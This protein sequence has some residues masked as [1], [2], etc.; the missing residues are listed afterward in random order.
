MLNLYRILRWM[1]VADKRLTEGCGDAPIPI[2][3]LYRRRSR[4]GFGLGA[5]RTADWS[6][7][8]SRLL[9]F[10]HSG[11]FDRGRTQRLLAPKRSGRL[12]SCAVGR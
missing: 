5:I 2:S 8:H 4:R 9:G 1:D 12:S 11:A 10:R 7:A 3:T 6:A